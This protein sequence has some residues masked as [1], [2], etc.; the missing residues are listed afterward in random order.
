MDED[1]PVQNSNDGL[2][3]QRDRSSR[4]MKMTFTKWDWKLTNWKAN[5]AMIRNGDEVCD[6]HGYAPIT[7]I[8]ASFSL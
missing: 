6:S 7:S 8:S 4:T 2:T 3:K 5:Q 1:D